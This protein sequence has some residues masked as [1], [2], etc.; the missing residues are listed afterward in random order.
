MPEPAKIVPSIPKETARA[1]NAVFGR[2]NFFILL[3]EQMENILDGIHPECALEKISFLK[4]QGGIL[5]LVTF[6]QFAE[7]LT[8]VQAIDALRTRI[9]WKFALHLPLMPGMIHERSLCMFRRQTLLDS[10]CL[11]QFQ[12]LVDRLVAFHPSIC[13]Q[14][15]YIKG[16]DV[17]ALV[18][19]INRLNRA[20]QAMNLVLEILAARFPEW[21]RRVALPHW[22]GRYNYT[23]PRLDVAIL[24]GQ[25]RFFV[26]EIGA[27]I[28]HLLNEI[29]QSGSCEISRLY[30]VQMLNQVWMQQFQT[31]PV[32]SAQWPETISQEDC[33]ACAALALEG[34]SRPA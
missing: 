3:G 14:I 10:V 18:C 20:Q 5:A 27:D 26:E 12:M 28:H 19:S 32:T 22:Y 6:F 30:E 7:G 23:I 29:Q 33:D 13:T 25:Q 15:Q 31:L 24:L 2:G 16:A 9:D 11:N 21:L 17:I 8:D 1:A 4:G 34:G